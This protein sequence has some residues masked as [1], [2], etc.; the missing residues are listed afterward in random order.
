MVNKAQKGKKK[1]QK[2]ESTI[3]YLETMNIIVD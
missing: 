3:K 1:R 2:N